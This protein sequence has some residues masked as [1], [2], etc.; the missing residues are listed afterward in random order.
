MKFTTFVQWFELEAPLVYISLSSSFGQEGARFSRLWNHIL[1]ISSSE[2][3]SDIF[4]KMGT[5]SWAED[6]RFGQLD[7]LKEDRLCKSD[8]KSERWERIGIKSDWLMVGED[9]SQEDKGMTRLALKLWHSNYRIP[10]TES[11]SA[12]LRYC[13]AERWLSKVVLPDSR[14]NTVCQPS[15]FTAYIKMHIK[16]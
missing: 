15:V 6:T 16:I 14:P 4:F 8:C 1:I 12:V 13:L 11:R 2:V 7:F 10:C 5:R 9:F 3:K